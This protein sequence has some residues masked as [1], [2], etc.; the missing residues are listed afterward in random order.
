MLFISSTYH[1]LHTNYLT[2]LNQDPHPQNRM[3]CSS[4]IRLVYVWL[5]L[6]R[7][8]INYMKRDT[9]SSFCYFCVFCGRSVL[10]LNDGP[11]TLLISLRKLIKAW[12]PKPAKSEPSVLPLPFGGLAREGPGPGEATGLWPGDMGSQRRTARQ[13]LWT[14]LKI[15]SISLTKMAT[16]PRT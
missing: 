3:S 12:L 15:S 5:N 13:G 4:L 7:M 14:N 8:F 6:R 10:S 16:I 2:L 11:A 9:D 1:C